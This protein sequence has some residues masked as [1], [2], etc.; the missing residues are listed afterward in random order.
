MLTFHISET[1]AK[2]MLTINKVIINISFL[3]NLYENCAQTYT[4]HFEIKEN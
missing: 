2:S 3:S 4:Q 1:S